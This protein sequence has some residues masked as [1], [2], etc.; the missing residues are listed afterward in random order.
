MR[1]I[2][3]N[4][5]KGME[6]VKKCSKLPLSISL[7]VIVILFIIL[8]VFII[9]YVRRSSSSSQ[10]NNGSNNEKNQC[11][12]YPP[13]PPDGT[14]QIQKFNELSSQSSQEYWGVNGGQYFVMFFKNIGD[15]SGQYSVYVD[16]GQSMSLG[17]FTKN[18]NNV[19]LSGFTQNI[20]A[21]VVTQLNGGNTTAYTLEIDDNMVT[22][23]IPGV[24][25]FLPDNLF[26]LTVYSTRK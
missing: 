3:L 12:T 2:S 22:S 21:D 13:T 10:D 19:T 4:R 20:N 24:G 1:F 8:I 18:S 26:L 11:S 7:I 17:N 16:S 5:L 9:L 14:K 25:N 6:S 23:V 15:T